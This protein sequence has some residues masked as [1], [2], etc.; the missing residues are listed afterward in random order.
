MSCQDRS[1]YD[2]STQD[3]AIKDRFSRTS[4]AGTVQVPYGQ[5]RT[6]QVRT[7]QVWTSQLYLRMEFDSGV[8]PT[9]P[10]HNP[11]HYP[12]HYAG[13]CICCLKCGSL[14]LTRQLST[15]FTGLQTF[16][17]LNFQEFLIKESEKQSLK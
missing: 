10:M 7:G 8:G 6:C 4:E 3:R 15:L 2:R 13:Y 16:N 9:C 12:M 5:V 11:M 17:N 14:S 1:C